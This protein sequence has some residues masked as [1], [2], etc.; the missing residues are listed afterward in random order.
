MEIQKFRLARS[1][2]KLHMDVIQYSKSVVGGAA[3]SCKL[4]AN[5]CDLPMRSGSHEIRKPVG[6]CGRIS[7]ASNGLTETRQASENRNPATEPYG[8]QRCIKY[9]Y[10]PVKYLCF[11]RAAAATLTALSKPPFCSSW[12]Y[13]VY[14]EHCRLNFPNENSPKICN[15]EK[16][17][18]CNRD[19]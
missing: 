17:M 13:F 10:L 16:E 5:V 9:H 15:S 19:S 1:T 11:Y 8:S 2:S 14:G 3:K 18:E 7:K 6:R 12:S 4:Q